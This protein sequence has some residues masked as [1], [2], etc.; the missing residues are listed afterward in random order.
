MKTYEVF[1]QSEISKTLIFK[2]M[3]KQKQ[4]RLVHIRRDV[5]SHGLGNS[6]NKNFM[7]TRV[8]LYSFEYVGDG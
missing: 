6:S 4:W 3:S 2:S 8:K 5:K 7:R 1:L